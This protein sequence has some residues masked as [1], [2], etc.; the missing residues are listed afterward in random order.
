MPAYPSLHVS[1][2]SYIRLNT[3][4]D[5]AAAVVSHYNTYANAS[6]TWSELAAQEILAP[7]NMTHSFF[8]AVPDSHFPSISVPGGE[9]WADL[10]V[11]AGYD[12][13]AGMWVRIWSTASTPVADCVQSSA[14]DLV[15]YM[16]E[17][18][19][20]PQPSLIAPYQ[21]RRALKPTIILPDGKQQV[22]PGWEI[23]LLTAS[24]NSSNITSS[25]DS[26]KTYAIY[27]KS[28]NGG[29]WQ[30]WVDVVPNLG[31]GL[32]VL[33]QASGMANYTS[34][35]QSQIHSEAHEILVP[36]F[37]EALSARMAARFAGSY[38]A[39]RDGGITADQVGHG[40][41]E[42][43]TTYARVE[44]EDQVLYLRELVVNGSSALEAVD[45][46]G[47]SGDTGPRLFST[48][49]GVVLE[50]AEGA[51]ESAAFGE[52][53][54]VFRMTFP[55]LDVCDWFDYDGYKGQKGWPLDKVVVVEREGTAAV[56][57]HYPPFDVVIA[58]G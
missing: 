17:I 42:N 33:G 26:M 5:S 24:S 34:I 9:N 21:R 23:E 10:V 44:V 38:T 53:A 51:G 4:I 6:L 7:L 22:G 47:W 29:G 55:G 54:Q 2:H 45:R 20:R 52:G 49:Q 15:K 43:T 36:A 50:P 48:P 16:H 12:P 41:T 3:D 28:G 14:N 56:E 1:T 40:R 8:G 39:S 37:A 57:L 35:S 27:G 18:W 13:A 19:L 30:A 25:T 31:Y 32:V 46:L 11:G 58:R